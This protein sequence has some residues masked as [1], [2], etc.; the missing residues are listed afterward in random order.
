[1]FIVLAWQNLSQGL[2]FAWQASVEL[3]EQHCKH[4]NIW[5]TLYLVQKLNKNMKNDRKHNYFA[6]PWPFAMLYL[7]PKLLTITFY[8]PNKTSYRMVPKSYVEIMETAL[9][10][11]SASLSWTSLC[12][13]FSAKGKLSEL[14]PFCCPS[15]ALWLDDPRTAARKEDWYLPQGGTRIARLRRPQSC[16]LLSCLEASFHKPPVAEVPTKPLLLL[17]FPR[18]PAGI[19]TEAL[20]ATFAKI[21]RSQ[22]E[23]ETVHTGL[24]ESTGVAMTPYCQKL[25]GKQKVRGRLIRIPRKGSEACA[26]TTD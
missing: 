1:M 20:L 15:F 3:V 23:E 24:G 8:S 18:L 11:F 21:P 5:R 7:K 25:R 17:G 2:F 4:S 26:N 16:P 22:K 12:W 6:P 19:P 14:G 10:L 13:P 9:T